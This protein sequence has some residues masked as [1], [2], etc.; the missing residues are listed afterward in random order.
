MRASE[1]VV[2]AHAAITAVGRWISDQQPL[3]SSRARRW[4]QRRAVIAQLDLALLVAAPRM[5]RGV[6][7]CRPGIQKARDSENARCDRKLLRLVGVEQRVG[8][9]AQHLAE[10]PAKVVA[11]LDTRVQAPAHR[12]AY[13]RGLRPR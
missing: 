8:R 4:G 1:L 13:E 7:F 9:T 3:S 10:L 12:L 11:V 2:E 6:P 5:G